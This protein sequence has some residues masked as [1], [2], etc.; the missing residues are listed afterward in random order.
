[1]KALP[2][3][4]AQ[5]SRSVFFFSG[6]GIEEELDNQILLPSDWLHPELE[7]PDEAL[8]TQN[9]W[10]ALS[11]IEVPLHFLFLDACQ[12]DHRVFQGQSVQGRPVLPV[13][14][15]RAANPDCEAPLLY[16]SASG[17]VAYQPRTPADGCSF[18]G[19]AVLEGLR[20]KGGIKLDLT[21]NPILVDLSTLK[22]FL[23]RRVAALIREAHRTVAYGNGSSLAG[24]RLK[25]QITE[26]RHLKSE[27]RPPA[28]RPGETGVAGNA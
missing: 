15:A 18:F 9:V 17:T 22:P 4:A 14:K 16:A 19:Q 24:F 23:N 2:L 7:N 3:K 26:I 20:G 12:S 25:R 13:P 21:E 10:K 8:S 6:H 11:G 5:A 27:P 28:R 1:M